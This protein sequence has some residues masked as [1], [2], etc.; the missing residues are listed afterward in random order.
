MN[1]VRVG[2]NI[3]MF[4]INRLVVI[5]KAENDYYGNDFSFN[6]KLNIIRGENS[7]GKS[8][9]I[10][11][12]FYAL[13]LEELIDRKNDSVLKS[14]V[15]ELIDTEEGKKKVDESKVYLEIS[16][17]DNKIITLERSIKILNVDSR[18]VKVYKC[19]YEHIK[20]QIPEDYYLHDAGAAKNELGFHRFLKNLYSG[21]YQMFLRIKKRKLNYISKQFFL[22]F[23]LNKRM[24]G[25]TF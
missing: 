9:C 1:F 21:T 17:H 7:H 5:I 15:R 25:E 14:A 16:S 10:D 11:L 23:L 24:D 18:I 12:I 3:P 22:V 20:N 19:N 2:E 8:T 4:K 13:G 6:E